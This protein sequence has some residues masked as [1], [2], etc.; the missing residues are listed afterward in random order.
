MLVLSFGALCL[1]VALGALLASGRLRRAAL[2]HGAA[3][4]AGVVA[5]WIAVSRAR[6]SGPFA[7][8]TLG[9]V[10]TAFAGG[11]L[12]Y[13]LACRRRLRPGLLV[14]VH[15]IA[16][17]LGTLLLAGFVLGGSRTASR[18]CSAWSTKLPQD[19]VAT[20]RWTMADRPPS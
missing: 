11:V 17:G 8:D 10:S 9:L 14:F 6:L 15:A 2:L 4:L 16:G 12:L 13:A 1:T 18:P 7:W 20:L 19:R 3:G 5:L